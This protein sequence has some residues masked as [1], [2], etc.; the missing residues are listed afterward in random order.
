MSVCLYF[1]SFGLANTA[2]DR[3]KRNYGLEAFPL[4][5]IRAREMTLYEAESSR[6]PLSKKR[7]AIFI[8]GTSVDLFKFSLV[9]LK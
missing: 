5:A 8:A 7:H 1:F 2:T 9:L 4:L 3:E 6:F